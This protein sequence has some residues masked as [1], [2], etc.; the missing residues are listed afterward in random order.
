MSD[1]FARVYQNATANANLQQAELIISSER[2]LS[3]KNLI[4]VKSYLTE[5]LRTSGKCN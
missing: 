1:T 4:H 3:N 2:V 5:E